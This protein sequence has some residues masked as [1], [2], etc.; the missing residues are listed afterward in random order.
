ME[1]TKRMRGETSFRHQE[2]DRV[3]EVQARNVI[4][5]IETVHRYGRYPI[6]M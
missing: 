5:M 2:P 4:A 6:G 3:P 1:W